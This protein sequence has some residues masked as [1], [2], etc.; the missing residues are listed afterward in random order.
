MS[1][2]LRAFL[3]TIRKCE[4]T[5]DDNGYRALFGHRADKPK[6]FSSFSDHPRIRT[7]EKNDEFIRNNKLDYT[8]AA[9]AY[10]IT[11]TTWDRLVRKL[12]KDILP[13]FSPESQ[14]R[15]ALELIKEQRALE[16]VELGK[17]ES[18]IVK[19]GPIWASLPSSTV[20]QP[21]RTMEECRKFFI[22]A[23]GQL[24]APGHITP[25]WPF[26][27]DTMAL[28]PFAIPAILSMME[29]VPDLIR[30]FGKKDSES[31]ERNAK[32][33]EI[34]VDMAKTVT[35]ARTEQEASET[36]RASPEARREM[37]ETIKE[38]WFE[39][40][41]AS[42]GGIAGAAERS[43]KMQGDRPPYMNP[44]LW[45]TGAIIPL[46]YIVFLVVVLGKDYSQDVKIMVIQAVIG[47]LLSVVSFWLGSSFGSRTKDTIRMEK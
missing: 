43:M 13:D 1:A 41:E 40:T 30:I 32:A 22:A 45:V 4:G 35:G 19:C 23:G 34:V 29:S 24:E 15:A 10:Q 28:G 42:G 26:K 36:L 12:G 9:G 25:P 44:A 17:L 37:T 8:T 20:G 33:A 47:G 31:V 18:A 46:V 16:D 6:L 5:A 21:K 38:H 7:Y 27:E 14:D 39:L 11:E 3:F 2:N